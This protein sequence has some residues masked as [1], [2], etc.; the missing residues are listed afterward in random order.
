MKGKWI[1]IITKIFFLLLIVAF[2]GLSVAAK[3]KRDHLHL[4]NVNILINHNDGYSFITEKEVLA[5]LNNAFSDTT[6]IK[7]IDNLNILKKQVEENPF[8]K[9]VD[10]FVDHK[11]QINISVHQRKPLFRVVNQY[12]IGYY[13][14]NEGFKF[15]LSNYAFPKVLIVSGYVSENATQTGK[16]E[17]E[18][19]LRL[20]KWAKHISNDEYWT[21]MIAQIYIDENGK[22]ELITRLGN[23]RVFVDDKLEP[24]VQ[25]EK[26]QIFLE[27]IAQKQGWEKYKT[28]NVQFDGQ[29]ICSKQTKYEKEQ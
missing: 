28:I 21:S 6:G 9:E 22:T 7:K 4:K 29:I 27:E 12:N 23:Y 16:I 18:K 5:K 17:K 15:P 20:F 10:V 3:I 19:M 1:H 8:V 2:A 25:L 13:V 26:L 14:D 11:N 24:Q